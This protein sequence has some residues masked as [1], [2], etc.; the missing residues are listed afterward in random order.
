MVSRKRMLIN[1]LSNV[2]TGNARLARLKD[3]TNPEIRELA[4]AAHF[5]GFGVAE[6]LQAL[7]EEDH[8]NDLPL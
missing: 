8:E 1:A 4:T 7:T 2:A 3:S 6:A 5:I